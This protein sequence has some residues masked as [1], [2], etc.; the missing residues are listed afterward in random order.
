MKNP[1]EKSL[2]PHAMPPDMKPKHKS[3]L[4]GKSKRYAVLLPTGS[5]SPDYVGINMK[6]GIFTEM[7]SRHLVQS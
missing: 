7:S 1:T 3:N 5:Q 2:L 6:S 4:M